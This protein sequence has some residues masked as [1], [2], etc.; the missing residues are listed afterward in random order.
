MGTFTVESPKTADS[1]TII[2]YRY[3]MIFRYLKMLLQTPKIVVFQPE[4]LKHHGKTGFLFSFPQQKQR[5]MEVSRG[6]TW[7]FG[8]MGWSKKTGKPFSL[9]APTSTTSPKIKKHCVLLDKMH[10]SVIL[11]FIL[12]RTA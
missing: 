12:Q 4:T 6:L 3:L 10:M 1:P 8:Q 9:P 5:L 11:V 2:P 7:A